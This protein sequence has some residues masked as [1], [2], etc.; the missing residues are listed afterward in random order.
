VIPAEELAVDP[1]ARGGAWVRMQVGPV[2][3]SIG[4]PSKEH[5]DGLVLALTGDGTE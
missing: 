3:V 5:V 2:D 1:I 4:L